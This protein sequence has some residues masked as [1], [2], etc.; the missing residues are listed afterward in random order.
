LKAAASCRTPNFGCGR[1]PRRENRGVFSL[2]KAGERID[3][4]SAGIK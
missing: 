1:L 3:K 4:L 2:K